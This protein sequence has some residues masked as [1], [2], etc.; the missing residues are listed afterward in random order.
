MKYLVSG[1]VKRFETMTFLSEMSTRAIMDLILHRSEILIRNMYRTC[2]VGFSHA[3]LI[4]IK[5][6][7]L[8][9]VSTLTYRLVA[10]PI[11]VKIRLS[12]R[13]PQ[14][15]PPNPFGFFENFL[16]TYF[17]CNLYEFVR[18]NLFV[19]SQKPTYIA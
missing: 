10:E 17:V 9:P 6:D 19:N 16:R 4:L 8:P 11:A 1:R 2:S 5:I 7:Y 13:G 15:P 14:S 12:V 3:K 18:I